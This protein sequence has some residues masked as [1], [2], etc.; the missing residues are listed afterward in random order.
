MD[1][2]MARI[3]FVNLLAIDRT[4]L[5]DYDDDPDIRDTVLLTGTGNVL[6][7]TRCDFELASMFIRP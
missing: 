1:Q 2:A 6:V 7:V 3:E 4:G 5:F